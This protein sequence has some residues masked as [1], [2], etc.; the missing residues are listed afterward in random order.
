MVV[1]LVFDDAVRHL[2]GSCD[3]LWLDVVSKGDLFNDHPSVF[4]T[5]DL[6]NE[7]PDLA[8]YRM[9][10][11]EGAIRVSVKTKLGLDEV[12][13]HAFIYVNISA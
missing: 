10:G 4:V 5:E 1:I 9:F 11:P 8:R 12:G 6:N 13:D 3:H 2:R 7:N